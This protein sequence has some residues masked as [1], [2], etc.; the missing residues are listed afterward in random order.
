MWQNIFDRHLVGK[1]VFNSHLTNLFYFI[2]FLQPWEQS[3]LRRFT[4][5]TCDKNCTALKFEIENIYTKKGIS[6]HLQDRMRFNIISIQKCIE[7]DGGR[8][9]LFSPKILSNFVWSFDKLKNWCNKAICLT[10]T[11]FIMLFPI[12]SEEILISFQYF[13]Y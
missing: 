6:I 12:N 8:E 5:T 1:M 3:I 13:L 11:F 7:N 2:H 9:Y 4:H 10:F